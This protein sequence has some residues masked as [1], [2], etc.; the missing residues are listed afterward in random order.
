[1]RIGQI[2]RRWRLAEDL[3]LREVA[4][5]MGVNFTTLSRIEQGQP[6]DGR[7]LATILAWM[8]AKPERAAQ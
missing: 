1:M 4:K 3:T 5:Q 7:T 6:M 2:L 8:F